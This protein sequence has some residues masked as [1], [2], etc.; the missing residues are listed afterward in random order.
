[1]S[2]TRCSEVAGTNHTLNSEGAVTDDDD[3]DVMVVARDKILEIG[4]VPFDAARTFDGSGNDQAGN[5]APNVPKAFQ[6]S[7]TP[8]V[9]K[10]LP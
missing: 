7:V 5:P 2:T 8:E 6:V 4:V 1:M 9:P 10:S 3:T